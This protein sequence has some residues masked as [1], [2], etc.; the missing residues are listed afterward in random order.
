MRLLPGLRLR[1]LLAVAASG[2][3][4][5]VGVAVAPG[6]AASAT[7][8]PP[9][10]WALHPEAF[11][12]G[13]TG[14]DSGPVTMV[15]TTADSG[16]GSLRWATGLPGPRR[17]GF[18]VSGTIALQ[19]D[20]EVGPSTTIDGR[21]ADITITGRGL[22]L[23]QDD[24]VLRNLKFADST[25]SDIEQDAVRIDGADH[26]WIDH[27]TMTNAG[28]KSIDMVRGTDLT[29]SW[30]H[31]HHQEQV[32]QLGTYSTQAESRDIRVTLHHNFFDTNGYR[33]PLLTYGFV[34]A[35]DNYLY[36]W[37]VFGMSAIRG[38]RLLSQ[39]NVFEA[40]RNRR[41]I[42]S[43]GGKADK[44][45][46]PGWTRSVGDL[47]LNGATPSINAPERVPTPWLWLPSLEP[48]SLGLRDRVRTYAGW[49]ATPAAFS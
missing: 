30:S 5:A 25:P 45:R 14:G 18:A 34:Q 12:A 39:A 37:Q 32:I 19:R 10:V 48:A 21:G 46:S 38:A 44:D 36:D 6:H 2:S 9:P 43:L 20:V 28:D 7:P 27:C 33:N 24:V 15:T 29:V 47:M 41:A 4:L 13:P 8:L 40:G 26:V 22:S 1:R 35:Y 49:Q 16:P 31:L 42:T 3:V 17:I 11:G 23:R